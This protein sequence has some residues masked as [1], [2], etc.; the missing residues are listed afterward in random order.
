[1][2]VACHTCGGAGVAQGWRQDQNLPDEVPRRCDH[3]SRSPT[4]VTGGAFPGHYDS[5]VSHDSNRGSHPRAL[6]FPTSALEF[7]CRAVGFRIRKSWHAVAE[8]LRASCRAVVAP[9]AEYG[10]ST[11]LLII[12]AI[13]GGECAHG[14][15]SRVRDVHSRLACPREFPVNMA[16][17]PRE[18]PI[19]GPVLGSTLTV[20]VVCHSLAS[21][22]SFPRKACPWRRTCSSC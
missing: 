11:T 21:L 8:T 22:E 5:L 16:D 1:V 17:A 3:E 7:S 15:A 19:E 10:C 2:T 13:A 4:T 6:P 20:T 12:A 18:G 14:L 9:G